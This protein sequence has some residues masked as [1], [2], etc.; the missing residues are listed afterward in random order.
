MKLI[1]IKT[2]KDCPN[3]HWVWTNHG[4][5]TQ[6]CEAT[7]ED[8]YCALCNDDENFPRDCKL[9]NGGAKE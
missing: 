9:K 1:E 3:R 4:G 5:H 8:G 6:I 7:M 2:P